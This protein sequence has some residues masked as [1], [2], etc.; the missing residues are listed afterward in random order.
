MPQSLETIELQS[1]LDSAEFAGMSETDATHAYC[2]YLGSLGAVTRV[3]VGN[4]MQRG[5]PDR[6]IVDNA[7]TIRL[8]EFKKPRVTKRSNV[9][10]TDRA[11]WDELGLRASQDEFLSQ[12][13]S[14][15]G[16]L[17]MHADASEW[18]L[19]Q[20]SPYEARESSGAYVKTI[21]GRDKITRWLV[22]GT[23]PLSRQK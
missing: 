12:G 16:V 6:I 4:M 13:G 23:R 8:I 21:T 18:Q 5:L 19:W 7:G 3:L 22:N 10:Q 2:D 11:K 1:R 20:Y 14:N 17:I 15:C 9:I